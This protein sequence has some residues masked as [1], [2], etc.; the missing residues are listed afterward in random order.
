MFTTTEQI[1]EFLTSDKGN[2][3]LINIWNNLQQSFDN[4]AERI[5]FFNRIAA[6]QIPNT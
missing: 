2:D 3:K 1:E 5:S 6:K 4:D